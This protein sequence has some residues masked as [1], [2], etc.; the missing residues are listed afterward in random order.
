MLLGQFREV[1]ELNDADITGGDFNTSACRACG[2]AKLSSI[3]EA[4]EETLLIP[5]PPRMRDIQVATWW[6]E[7]ARA[8]TV[9]LGYQE[10]FV[11]LEAV[12]LVDLVPMCGQTEDSG[13]C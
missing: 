3:E 7:E 1:A 13:D 11:M 4:W 6:S 5:P 12:L 10:T 2:K 8:V 9:S